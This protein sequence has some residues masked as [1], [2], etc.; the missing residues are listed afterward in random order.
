[1]AAA[2]PGPT[3][4]DANIV[5][6]YLDARAARRRPAIDRAAA[7]TPIAE[8]VAEPLGLAVRRPRRASSRW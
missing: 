2:A 6:G 8:H 1:M 7:E 5:L 3:V 4:T